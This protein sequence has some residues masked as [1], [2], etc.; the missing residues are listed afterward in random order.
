MKTMTVSEARKLF[1]QA[2]DSVVRD[3]ETVIIV[4][5]RK[6]I[7]AIVPISQLPGAAQAAISRNHHTE[8]R[9]RRR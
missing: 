8:G 2:L 5:Y 7:A 9:R 6:P 1:A 4:R 3:D